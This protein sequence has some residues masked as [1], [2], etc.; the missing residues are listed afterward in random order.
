MAKNVVEYANEKGIQIIICDHHQ[1]PD[2][3]PDAFA[4]MD[5]IQKE[6]NYPFKHLCGTGVAFKLIQSVCKIRKDEKFAYSLL[7]F[8]AIATSSDI[9]PIIDE[10][11]ILVN[12]GFNIINNKP[13]LSIKALI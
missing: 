12:E 5:P 3:L 10:N 13:R 8:V 4:I 9:V 6:C 7:D 2:Q 11:R 1:P